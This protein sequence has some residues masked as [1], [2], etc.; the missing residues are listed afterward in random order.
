MMFVIGE[1]REALGDNP[2]DA[3]VAAAANPFVANSGRYTV[4]GNEITYEA[5]IAK[6]P[7]YMSQFEPTGGE[8]N[9]QTMTFSFE[10]GTMTLTFG[11]GGP[12]Q[13][14]TATLRKPGDG[15]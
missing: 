7:E 13:G 11:D 12:M 8:G 2:S 6:D 5:A 14:A 9:P 10:D 4:S 15:E 3:D 1:V